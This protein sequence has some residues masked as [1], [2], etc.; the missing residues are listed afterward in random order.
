MPK[1]FQ[2]GIPYSGAAEFSDNSVG[3][4]TAIYRAS[5]APDLGSERGTGG[6][7]GKSGSYRRNVVVSIRG[8]SRGVSGNDDENYSEALASGFRDI[9]N[10]FPP[11]GGEGGDR[12]Q[13]AERSLFDLM[14]LASSVGHRSTE[15]MVHYEANNPSG[16]EDED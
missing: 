7:G 16:Y 6:F 4:S 5:T 10:S 15:E 3:K 14:S 9:E 1:E 13:N 8:T 11:E 12:G 2:Y